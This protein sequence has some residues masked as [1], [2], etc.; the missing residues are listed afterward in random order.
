MSSKPQADAAVQQW[1]FFRAGDFD[2]VLIRNGADLAALG[3]L[4]K[5]LWATLSCPVHGLEFDTRTLQLIDGDNDDRIR[6]PEILAAIDFCKHLLK[7]LDIMVEGG[8]ALPLELIDDSHDDGRHILA[9]ARRILASL[10][11]EA[12]TTIS[13]DDLMAAHDV[14][15]KLPCNGDGIMPPSAVD[16]AA[17]RAVV[18]D[19]VA[20]VGGEA[21]R[22][23]EAGVS[24]ERLAQFFEA[25]QARLAWLQAA[26]AGGGILPLATAPPRPMRHCSPCARRSTTSSCAAAWRPT[27][28]APPRRSTA[29]RRITPRWRHGA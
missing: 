19:I 1:Q 26:Q 7:S 18:A 25:A 5:K 11:K 6:V 22:S 3:Q 2:Q 23:G 16:D 15:A 14:M 8:Q 4:D 27:M 28:H 29:P 17:L 13:V 10:G 20:C 9:S 12:T 24:A 21:D